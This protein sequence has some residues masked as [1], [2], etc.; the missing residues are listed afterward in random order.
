MEQ[1]STL[2]KKLIAENYQAFNLDLNQVVLDYNEYKSGEQLMKS[3]RN[4]LNR[5]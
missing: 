3:M 2:I 4:K 5:E 1:V